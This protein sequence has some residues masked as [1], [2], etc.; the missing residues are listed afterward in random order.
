MTSN[1]HGI[2]YF[3]FI[4]C[5]PKT[6]WR[7][8]EREQHPGRTSDRTSCVPSWHGEEKALPALH[9][10]ASPISSS[11]SSTC[12]SQSEE[13]WTQAWPNTEQARSQVQRRSSGCPRRIC[14]QHDPGDFADPQS[15]K[16]NCL[17]AKTEKSL[18]RTLKDGAMV[19]T[20]LQLQPHGIAPESIKDTFAVT[21][22]PQQSLKPPSCLHTKNKGKTHLESDSKTLRV[23]Q[24]Q[25]SSKTWK[26]IQYT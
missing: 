4:T 16:Q 10:E 3:H 6:T 14:T 13:K 15:Q 26:N 17:H 8:P 5:F 22:Q 25:R 19:R 1:A 18:L 24:G 7:A 21:E 20:S 2:T 12:V 9:Y 11:S 23:R